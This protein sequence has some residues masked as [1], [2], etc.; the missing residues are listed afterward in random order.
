M[1]EI[2][3]VEDEDEEGTPLFIPRSCKELEKL[4]IDV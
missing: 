1:D 3:C 4:S 2:F